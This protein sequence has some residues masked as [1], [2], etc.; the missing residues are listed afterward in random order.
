MAKRL[1]TVADKNRF[2]E[3]LVKQ[4]S[5]ELSDR[6]QQ[7]F[8]AFARLFFH[9]YSFADIDGRPWKDIL[10]WALYLWRLT[11]KNHNLPQVLLL[12][13]GSAEL[14]WHSPHTLLVVHQSDMPFLVDSIRIELAQRNIPIYSIKSMP[15]ELD[16]NKCVQP[17]GQ[18]PE[19]ARALMYLEIGYEGK[20]SEN[21][22]LVAEIEQVLAQVEKVVSDHQALRQSTF[23]VADNLLQAQDHSDYTAVEETREFLQWLL[24]DHFTFLGYSEFDLQDRKGKKALV[25][26][27]RKRLGLFDNKTA[28]RVKTLPES[29]GITRFYHST[30]VAAFSKSPERSRVHR[31]AYPDY[32]VVK[33][34]D[35]H[36]A[37]VGEARIL[38]LYTSSVYSVSPLNIP[39]VRKKLQHIY[40][41]MGLNFASHEG[42]ALAQIIDTFPRD[43]LF[44]YPTEEL[45]ETLSGV[46]SINERYQVRLFLR[47]DPF[48]KFVSALVYIPRDIF[49]THVREHIQRFLSRYLGAVDDEFTTW[50]SESVL[51][52]VHLV[53]RTKSSA[54]RISDETKRVEEKIADLIKPW[55]HKL[56][57]KLIEG[58]GEQLGRQ[59][60]QTYRKAFSDAYQEFY[61]PGYA[62]ED[63]VK[64]GRM[65]ET[66]LA[67]DIVIREDG[68]IRMRFYVPEESLK[69]SDIIPVVENMGLV[70]L[71]EHPFVISPQGQGQLWLHDFSLEARGGVVVRPELTEHMRNLFLAVWHKCVANDSFNRLVI[72]AGIDWQEVQVLRSYAEY[73]RQISFSFANEFIAD[74][75]CKHPFITRALIEYFCYKF[76]P[77]K[78]STEKRKEKLSEYEKEIIQKL[79]AV[80]NLNEDRILRQFLTLMQATLRCNYYQRP[81][82]NRFP[83]YLC[84]K[85]SSRHIPDVPQPRPQFEI[86]VNSLR[87][88]GVH[89][90]GSSVAR[91]GL[92]WSDRLQDYRTEVLGLVKAQ[93]VKNAVIVPGGAKGGFVCKQAEGLTGQALREEGVACYRQ[94][95]SALLDL[96]D[97][98]VEGAIEPPRGVVRYDDDD[99]YLVVAADKGTAT[100]SD[101]AN[102]IAADYNFWLGDAFASGGSQ[103]YDHKAMG[104]TA[105]GAWVS[106][107]RHFMERGHDVNAT[108][109]SV[110]GI[111]DM[112]GDVFGN[113]MLLSRKIKLL[114]AF[115]HRHIFI[116]PN[117][118]CESSYGE[119]ERLFNSADSSWDNYDKRR[120]S[121]GGGIFERSAKAIELTPEMQEVFAIEAQQLTPAQLIHHLLKAPVD[122]IWNGGIG[123]Y[124]KSSEESHSDVGDKSNDSL[125]VNG[126]E[127]RCQVIGEGGNLGMTQLG[128]IE[129]ALA[130]G[131]CNTDFIDNAA[132]VDCSDHEVN[133]KILLNDLVK[134]GQLDRSR[135]NKLLAT[136]TE[137]VAGLVLGNN[138]RQTLAIS[139]AQHDTAISTAEYRRFINY[140]ESSGR[141]NRQLEF[142]P[143]DE[144]LAERSSTG[145][146]LTRPELSVLIAYAKMEL[147]ELLASDA[148]REDAC[149]AEYSLRAFPDRLVKKYPDALSQ[150]RL[151]REIIATELA[152][153]IVNKLGCT[154]VQRMNDATGAHAL[155]IAQSFLFASHYFDFNRYFRALGELDFTVSAEAQLQLMNRL[156]GIVRRGARWFLRNYRQ[157]DNLNE[158]IMSYTRLRS[159]INK[160]LLQA[161]D[162]EACE[163]YR[164][165]LSDECY[166]DV[167]PELLDE[168]ILPGELYTGLGIA[169]ICLSENLPE[170]KVTTVYVRLVEFLR[171]DDFAY[172]LSRVPSD[173]Y[174]QSLAKESFMDDL[175]A[176]VK[177]LTQTLLQEARNT[178]ATEIVD[179]WAQQQS[180]LVERWQAMV[181]TIH[182]SNQGDYAMFAVALRELLDLVQV[183]RHVR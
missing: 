27:R 70:V 134:S 37:L 50:F 103:G 145:S 158:L 159:P 179:R 36:G 150:H 82:D 172:W 6:Q 95:I 164:G 16:Q 122:L 2:V 182:S 174:W 89:L 57:D 149:L 96:T 59:Y 38:G 183:S 165:Q 129:F 79:D 168:I 131:A 4:A 113:G 91:G 63:I 45:Q 54:S 43:E 135:R 83:D 29:G 180:A 116:D 105:R 24:N 73:M 44:Q 161:M 58:Y 144:T 137:D 112:G 25:E 163:R 78:I 146:G 132:G 175:E 39:L 100:F 61:S 12:R 18:T 52:R 143:D 107:W 22:G 173:N 115:N 5:G 169:H 49:S 26:N 20:A 1:F 31:N 166:K 153:D 125:R 130:G 42:K 9:R 86:Y 77:G 67:I 102:A 147:K 34:F 3:T 139:L 176:Q 142:L 71:A 74:A 69:L 99:P 93:Q 97:N 32:V 23:S 101:T 40:E 177:M 108:P 81:E 160:H 13:S 7:R 114:A 30:D 178:S 88:E 65:A 162:D 75:L 21:D 51:A 124:V 47:R 14:K 128:R 152:N 127:L 41:H 68:N 140:L 154:F 62:I 98:L 123:T 94:F 84:F 106:V 118:D 55:R 53:F 19:D 10:P 181:A 80:E 48:G 136:M 126:D 8:D 11:Q 120:I 148:V 87:F 64:I 33:R 138:Y 28:R 66:D 167:P 111:G 60:Y 85:L 15:Y 104:I 17:I 90:R 133:I 72:A 56:H 141:L 156:A 76:T 151:H 170:E 92:R 117:P 119:R 157:A 109:F 46:L 35:A 121:K 171:L 155:A 110:L